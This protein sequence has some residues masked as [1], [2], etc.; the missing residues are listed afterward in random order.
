MHR[1]ASL[2]HS[3]AR[4]AGRPAEEA[5]AMASL[6]TPLALQD[7]ASHSPHSS[8]KRDG[9]SLGSPQRTAMASLTTRLLLWGQET[10]V[11]L[12]RWRQVPGLA[13]H[14][15]QRA[16]PIPGSGGRLALGSQAS[17][18]RCRPQLP[19]SP[20]AGRGEQTTQH[21]SLGQERWARTGRDQALQLDAAAR[22]QPAKLLRGPPRLCPC[23]AHTVQTQLAEG[24]G[25]SPAPGSF[26]GPRARLPPYP[27]HD[28]G[29]ARGERQKAGRATSVYGKQSSAVITALSLLCAGSVCSSSVLSLITP[30]GQSF[31]LLRGTPNNPANLAGRESWGGGRRGRA[32]GQA[33]Q[34]ISGGGAPTS[35]H[36][37]PPSL[38][39]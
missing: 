24:P 37:L 31:S 26:H 17:R 18:P 35:T 20:D 6:G 29:A 9:G 2:H 4:E 1:A 23:G 30:T 7:A 21:A 15:K 19:R 13:L 33:K 14:A 34:Q 36:T 28:P 25:P 11:G 39:H 16:T 38:R 27:G 10:E 5:Q 22:D 12:Q 32:E 3:R 8:P